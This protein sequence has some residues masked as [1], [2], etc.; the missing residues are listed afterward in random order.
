MRGRPRFGG[1]ATLYP[2]AGMTPA[3]CER[4]LRLL[5]VEAAFSGGHLGAHHGGWC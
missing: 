2:Q 1:M 4:G 5:V 3:E